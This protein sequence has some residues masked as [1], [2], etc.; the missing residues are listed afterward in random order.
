MNCDG[1]GHELERVRDPVSLDRLVQRELIGT[2]AALWMLVTPGNRIC[3][4]VSSEVAGP[5]STLRKVG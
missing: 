4:V 3:A 2:S 5:P 1:R